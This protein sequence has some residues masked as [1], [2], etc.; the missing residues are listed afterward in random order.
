VSDDLVT[1]LLARLDED[2]ATARELQRRIGTDYFD[3]LVY[4]VERVAD[5]ARSL[6]DVAAK[7]A[8]LGSQT[9]D[10]APIESD[11]GLT[12]RTC[13]AWQDDEGAH[14]FGIAIPEAWPCR[15]ARAAAAVYS[16]HPDYRA[17]WALA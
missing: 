1:F 11:Y 4:L 2:E 17:E 5:P 3:D 16:T 8:I 6:R 7:R 9:S 12:C 14:E 10:H 13:V 15:V